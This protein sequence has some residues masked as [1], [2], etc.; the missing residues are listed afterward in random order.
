MADLKTPRAKRG[1]VNDLLADARARE[2][3]SVLERLREDVALLGITEPEIRRALDYD[4][5]VCA[6]AK[7]YDSAIGT[8]GWRGAASHMARWQTARGLRDRRA[9][10]VVARR[11][12]RTIG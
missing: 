8:S 7:Y 9:A 2:V 11:Q 3:T 12:V 1:H 10:A 6:P 4:R 5:P